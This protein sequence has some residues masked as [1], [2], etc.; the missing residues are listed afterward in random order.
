[1]YKIRKKNIKEKKNLFM[2]C[3]FTHGGYLMAKTT[4]FPDL[5][6]GVTPGAEEP[7]TEDRA[8]VDDLCQVHGRVLP[9]TKEP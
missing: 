8:K 5:R 6:M 7:A 3:G 4:S 1:M 2:M 9:G